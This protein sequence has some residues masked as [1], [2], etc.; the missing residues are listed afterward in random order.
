MPFKGANLTDLFPVHKLTLHRWNWDLTGDIFSPQKD[1]TSN[2]F[3]RK[4]Q[5]W[6]M[7]LWGI[8]PA[9]WVG[10][11]V[12]SSFLALSQSSKGSISSFSFFLQDSQSNFAFPPATCCMQE[13][14]S[15]STSTGSKSLERLDLLSHHPKA[16]PH[17]LVPFSPRAPHGPI[18]YNQIFP[19][20]SW[21]PFSHPILPSISCFCTMSLPS[22]V[23]SP[24]VYCSLCSVG[25]ITALL[26]VWHLLRQGYSRECQVWP[27]GKLEG[28][29]F[30]GQ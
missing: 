23:L 27:G 17:F 12:A 16:R 10:G 1:S 19:Q 18:I 30:F 6:E 9:P 4:R 13:P 24:A 14:V 15:M 3:W 29:Y 11:G 22:Y 28:T 25:F 2:S 26:S 20:L 8:L 21:L 7:S 5:L